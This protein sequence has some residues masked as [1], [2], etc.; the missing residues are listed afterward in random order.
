[1]PIH[2]SAAT[3]GFYDDNV[4][5]ALP[6]DALPISSERHRELLEGQMQGLVIVAH[7]SGAPVLRQPPPPT[8]EELL[9]ALRVQRD[10]QLRETDWTQ[11]P[12]SPLNTEAREGW[13]LYRQVLRDLPNNVTD[14]SNVE[15]PISPDL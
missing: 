10:R 3:G 9:A 6:D 14:A 12:D 15:W 8:Q 13:R 4:H 7:D 5:D 11:M 2:F 1:M